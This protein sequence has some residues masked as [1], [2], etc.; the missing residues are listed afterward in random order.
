MRRTTYSA[1]FLFFFFSVATLAGTQA[2]E[3]RVLAEETQARGYWVDP[4]S[5]LMWAGKDNGKDVSWK[6]AVRYLP[7]PAIGLVLRLEAG[8][9][10]RIGRNLR[11]ECRIP[12]EDPRSRWHDA[13]RR[14]RS[15]G[16][17][18]TAERLILHMLYEFPRNEQL[19]IGRMLC[20]LEACDLARPA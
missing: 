2:Q 11:Q 13:V 1:T 7:R 16:T 15:G 14:L 17:D 5:G 18:L 10:C 9:A 6:N 12:G 4:S 8:D 20:L 3:E 19:R